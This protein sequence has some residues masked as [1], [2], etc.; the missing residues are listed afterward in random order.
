MSALPGD[1]TS[2]ACVSYATS[3]SVSVPVVANRLRDGNVTAVVGGDG[4]L[5]TTT[6]VAGVAC[7]SR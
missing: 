5:H 2:S 3:G 1:S 7:A 6:A 4:S